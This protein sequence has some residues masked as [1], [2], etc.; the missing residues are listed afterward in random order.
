MQIKLLSLP[1]KSIFALFVICF[2]FFQLHAG[3]KEKLK[4][5]YPKPLVKGTEVPKGIP[6]LEKARAK[7]AKPKLLE[8]PKGCKNVAVDK[9]VTGSDEDPSVGELD[10]ITDGDA[11]GREFVQFKKG[12]Q[13][14]VIDLEEEYELHA[15]HLWHYHVEPRVYYDVVIQVSND[16]DFITGV[17]TVFNNDHDN[18]SGLGKGKD[19]NYIEEFYGKSIKIK[20][21]KGQ[22]V[23]LWS[24]GSSGDKANHYVEVQV[25]GKESK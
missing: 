10:M 7:G 13:N 5:K 24:K 18:S 12:L 8:I 11:D 1:M 23:R 6:N 2:G 9:E 20:P 22:Y 25:Y 14:I 15:V 4:I 19:K 16:P 17:K 21:T 3:D